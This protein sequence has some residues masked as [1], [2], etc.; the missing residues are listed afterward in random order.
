MQASENNKVQYLW[1]FQL[2]EEVKNENDEFINTIQSCCFKHYL[3]VGTEKGRILI[4]HVPTA[5]LRYNFFAEP[6]IS[7]IENCH[8]FIWLSG[9][10]RSMKCFR[11]M[12]Q[13][14][15]FH[16]N[17]DT[18][19]S[20]YDCSG[21]QIFKEKSHRFFLYN[22]KYSQMRVM[23]STQ[24]KKVLRISMHKKIDSDGYQQSMKWFVVDDN[25][26]NIWFTYRN[27]HNLYIYSFRRREMI[28]IVPLFP[29]KYTKDSKHF[30]F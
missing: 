11:V 18:S 13:K 2:P 30:I 22:S 20:E 23:N 3:A 29:E 4:Y 7:S 1:D 19:I 17:N 25:Y 21:I 12:D 5:T 16:T 27:D 14:M 15:V 26:G 24:R 28:N 9:M 8:G 6:W 10:T